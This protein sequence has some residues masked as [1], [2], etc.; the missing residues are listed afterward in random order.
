M[1]S[2]CTELHQVSDE[3]SDYRLLTFMVLVGLCM[4]G[5]MW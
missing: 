3:N 5:F 1:H 2:Q 4:S